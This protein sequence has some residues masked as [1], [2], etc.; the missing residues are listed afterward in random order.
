MNEQQLNSILEEHRLWLETAGAEGRKADLRY[1]D[2]RYVA[3]READLR[4]AN[5]ERAGLQ[6]A[7][8]QGANLQGTYLQE[9]DLQGANLQGAFLEDIKGK[10]IISFQAGKH[11]AYYADSYIK[12][13]CLCES[14]SWWLENYK[15]VGKK[16]GYSEAEIKRY[17]SFIESI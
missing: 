17:G 7:Y 8:L 6:G 9:A 3:L 5:L 2:L 4:H 1:T 15:A 14:V 10:E 11:F 13:G 12:I 16:E